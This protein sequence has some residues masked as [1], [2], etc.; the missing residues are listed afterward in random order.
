M[1]PDKVKQLLKADLDPRF[2]KTRE[3]SG[4]KQLSYVDNHY[5]IA[6]ANEL[7]DNNWTSE[8]LRLEHIATVDYKDKNG[9]LKKNVG[10][11]ATVRVTING[12]FR[13]GS[14]YGDSIEGNEIKAHELALKEAETDARKRALMQFGNPFGLELYD[15]DMTF[16]NAA[17]MRKACQEIE[18]ALEDATCDEDLDNIASVHKQD[19]AMLKNS[20]SETERQMYGQLIA[21]AQRLRGAFKEIAEIRGD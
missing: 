10:Y 21:E 19:L 15:K 6:T 3:G 4:G 14:G 17:A 12:I 11:R 13:D 9:N 7:F 20:K 16:K 18:K 1:I 8:T 5:V 2:I